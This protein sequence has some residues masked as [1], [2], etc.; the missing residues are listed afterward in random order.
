[1][2]T[3]S[4]FITQIPGT[5]GIISTIAHRVGC[6]WHTVKRA[7]ERWPTVKA[8]YDDECEGILDLAEVALVSLI[9]KGDGPSVRFYLSTKGK[10]RGYVPKAI[11]EHQGTQEITVRYVDDWRG[12]SSASAAPGPADDQTEQGEVQMG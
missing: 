1:M 4:T 10:H 3:A 8:A 12:N 7:I 6:E 2:Y 9:K 5:G 11:Q